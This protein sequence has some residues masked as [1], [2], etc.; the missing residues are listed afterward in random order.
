MSLISGAAKLVSFGGAKRRKR[1]GGGKGGGVDSERW[2]EMEEE[3]A[4][5]GKGR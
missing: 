3:E 1:R 4:E 5:R 2:R